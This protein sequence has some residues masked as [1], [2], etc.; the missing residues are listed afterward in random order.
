MREPQPNRCLYMF[1]WAMNG[2]LSQPTA[3]DATFTIEHMASGPAVYEIDAW[4][5]ESCTV[6]QPVETPSSLVLPQGLTTQ[7][8]QAPFDL[9]NIFFDAEGRAYFFSNERGEQTLLVM[10]PD[11]TALPFME[12]E[13]LAGLNGKAGLMTEDGILMVV[14]YWPDG[15]NGHGGL[16]LLQPD[17]SFAQWEPPVPGGGLSEIV[18]AADGGWLLSDF[19]Y[20]NVWQLLAGGEPAIPLA[21]QGDRPYGVGAL[22]YDPHTGDLLALYSADWS[23]TST[24][25]VFHIADGQ[26]VRMI[27]APPG[28]DNLRDLAVSAGGVLQDGVYMTDPANGNILKLTGDGALT[29]IISGLTNPAM[30][31]FDPL[32]GRLLVV[33]DQD[34]VLVVR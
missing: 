2:R 14:D 16:F 26:A 24:T 29:P 18:P 4:Q 22:G 7:S 5:P 17:G 25:G 30:L 20:G 33:Y 1:R 23:G 11:G 10:E 19:E 13:L 27:D 8:Y 9:G 34:K 31:A 28:V 32:T 12:S 15:G 3:V 21:E 6:L